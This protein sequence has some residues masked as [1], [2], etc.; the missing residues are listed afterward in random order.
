MNPFPCPQAVEAF[1]QHS[2]LQVLEKHQ[3]E[4]QLQDRVHALQKTALHR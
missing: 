1:V 4:A 2:G 3:E